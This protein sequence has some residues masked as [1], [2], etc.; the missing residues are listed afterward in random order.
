MKLRAAVLFLTP[1]QQSWHD[2]QTRK[3]DCEVAGGAHQIGS[4]CG[5]KA[6]SAGT[7]TGC[8]AK[9][10]IVDASGVWG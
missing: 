9:T 7:G 10:T 4:G 1:D 3:G 8:S 2:E 6:G 5:S